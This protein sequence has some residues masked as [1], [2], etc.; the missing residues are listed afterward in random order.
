MILSM[1]FCYVIIWIFESILLYFIVW[2]IKVIYIGNIVIVFVLYWFIIL[3]LKY[4]WFDI[5]KGM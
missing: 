2:C 3:E 5:F 4:V 1:L